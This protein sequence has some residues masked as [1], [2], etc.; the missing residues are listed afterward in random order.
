MRN[1]LSLEDVI[2]AFEAHTWRYASTMKWVP[3]YYVTRDK[4]Q[5]IIPFDEIVQFIYDKGVPMRWGK[6]APKPYLDIGE[7]R[8]F[9]MGNPVPETTVINREKIAGSKA[10][11]A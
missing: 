5:H 2:S 4:W 10:I 9:C 3:H 1:T 6:K 7:W 11:P 8:Y